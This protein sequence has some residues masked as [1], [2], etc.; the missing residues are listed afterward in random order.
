MELLN[1]LPLRKHSKKIKYFV[2]QSPYFVPRQLVNILY[3]RDELPNTH[4]VR[5]IGE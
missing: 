1:G 5:K 2:T 4:L 3:L